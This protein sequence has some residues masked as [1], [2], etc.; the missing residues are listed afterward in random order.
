MR[1]RTLLALSLLTAVAACDAM[2]PGVQGSG[3]QARE[4]RQVP[5]FTAVEHDGSSSV[6]IAVG[7]AQR[8][9]V[10]ADDNVVPLILTTVSGDT[11][12]IS[13]KGSYSTKL[14]IKVTVTTPKLTAIASSGSGDLD[15][16]DIAGASFTA[17]MHGSGSV[18]LLGAVDDLTASLQGSGSLAATGLTAARVTVSLDGSGHAEVHAREQVTASIDGSGSVRYTGGATNVVQ[19]VSGSGKVAPL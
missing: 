14:P 3:A 10:E 8:V 2:G 19:R 7:P 18:K 9:T 11:L 12:K 13:S 6:D 1:R 15:A 5:A 16:R 17:A 4:D